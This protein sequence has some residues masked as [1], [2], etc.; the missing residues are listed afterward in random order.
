MKFWVYRLGL[1][2]GLILL[3]ISTYAE[4]SKD[5]VSSKGYRLFFNAQQRQQIKVYAKEGEFIQVGSSHVGI[6]GGFIR[7]IRPDGTDHTLFDNKGVNFQ[8]GII[9]NKT[10][11]FAGPTGGGTLNGPGYIPGVVPVLS[12]EE[13]IW[14]ITLEYPA[15]STSPFNNVLNVDNWQRIVDQPT[16]QRVVLAWDITVSKNAAAN[17]GGDMLTGRVFTQEIS[18]VVNDNGNLT[19]IDLYVLSDEG[20]QYNLKMEDMDPWGWFLSSNNRGIVDHERKPILRS[21]E[22]TEFI[23]SWQASSWLSGNNYLYEPQT[24]DFSPIANNKLFFN[25]PDP[26]LPLEASDFDLYRNIKFKNWLNPVIPNYNDPLFDVDFS[27]YVADT[28]IYSICGQYVMGVGQGGYI[29]FETVGRGEVELRID[30]NQN[31]SYNDPEDVSMNKEVLGGMDSIF[32]DGKDNFGVPIPP[33]KNFP[34]TLRMSGTIY[35]GEMHFLVF[36]VENTTGGVNLTRLNGVNPGTVSFLYDHSSFGGGVSGGGIPGD[37]QPTDQ[38]YSYSNNQGDEKMMDY[39][40]FISTSAISDEVTLMIDIVD[41][42]V[43]PSLDSDGDGIIDVIDLDDDNDG[44]PDIREFCSVVGSF[45]CL[46]GGLDP[47]HDEDKDKIL[48]FRDANDPAFT[49]P[50]ADVDGDGIC[51]QVDGIYDM[52]GD[53][54]PDHLD[55]DSDNDGVPDMYEAGHGLADMEGNGVINAPVA[56]FGNNGFYNN[57][58]SVAN[59]QLAVANYLPPDK[60]NDGVPDN[61]DRESDNDGINDVAEEDMQGL[62][63]NN[64]GA[65]DDG[66]GGIMVDSVGIPLQISPS[67][68]GNPLS[69]PKDFD[70]DGIPNYLD[71]DSDNDGL[72]DVI[73]TVNP[74]GD[75]NGFLGTG[76]DVDLKVNEFGQ[77]YEDGAGNPVS[78]TSYPVNTD[79]LGL[80]DFQDLDSDADGIWDT[81]E[82][83]V[84]DPDQDGVSGFGIP[85]VNDFGVPIKDENGDPLVNVHIPPDYDGDGIPDFQD[86]DSD[87]DGISDGYE[88]ETGVPCPD[89]DADGIPDFHDLDSDNDGLGDTV[90]CPNGDDPDCPD[91]DTDGVDDFRDPNSFFTNDTDGDGVRDFED[92]DN[93]NDGIPDNMEFCKGIQGFACLPGAKDPDGD[94]DGDFIPNYWDSKDLAVNNG[95]VDVN[96]DGICDRV[97]PAYDTD[98]D[99]VAN[100]VDLDSD[101]DGLTDLFEAG[102]DGPDMNGNGIIDGPKAIF[103][104]NGLYNP[105]A[106]DPDAFTATINYVRLNSDGDVNFDHLDLDSDN[107]GTYDAAEEGYAL[108]DSDD[109][110]RLDDGT[111]SPAV[112]LRGIALQIDPMNT[113]DPLVLPRDADL[114]G[115]PDYRD[116]DS[117]NDGIHDVLENKGSDADQDGEPGQ[118]P[119]NV[120]AHGRLL[121]DAIGFV[122]KST[123]FMV[124]TD[125]DAEPDYL[126]L[127]SDGDTLPDVVE[128]PHA[129]PD[130]DFRPGVSPVV[131]NTRGA[132]IMDATGTLLQS[133]SNPRDLDLDLAPDFQDIDRDG[134]GIGDGYECPDPWDCVDSDGDGMPDVDDLNSDND[135]WTD[136]DECP[137]GEPCPDTDMNFVDEFRQFNCWP[138]VTPVLEDLPPVI[139]VCQGSE[140]VLSG[141]NVQVFPA[142]LTYT[143]TGPG[144]YKVTNTVPNGAPLTA[145]VIANLAAEG[146]YTLTVLSSQGCAGDTVSLFL[147]VK[148]VPSTPI[149]DID[150]AEICIG[151]SIILSSQLY[152]GQDVVYTWLFQSPGGS[153]NAIG[154]SLEP[155][156][157]LQNAQ[158]DDDGGYAVN[159]TVEGCTSANALP[160]NLTVLPAAI[161]VAQNDNYTIPFTQKLLQGN[162][163]T[164]DLFNT[165]SVLVT[166]VSGPDHGILTMS[167]DGSF[168]YEPETG[169]TGTVTIV[170]SICGSICEEVCDEGILTIEIS[171][172]LTPTDCDIPNMITPNADGF[173]DLFIIPCLEDYPDHEISIFNRWGDRVFF[174]DDYQQDWDGTYQGNPLPNTTYFYLIQF[175]GANPQSIQGWVE[176]IRE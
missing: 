64:D 50:C 137:G 162:L 121:T 6:A 176:I 102:H 74:D 26:G 32:W 7:V 51:D 20:I 136:E 83:G 161:V 106:T 144:L 39:W 99:G 149:I 73:E 169:F 125:L 146:N 19:D 54:V 132:L 131:V 70:G 96:N 116:I 46:P 104:A 143:W 80:P 85:M 140:I 76:A 9:Y 128:A 155:I 22:D 69:S 100:H 171:E 91:S 130:K 72:M 3:G 138:D 66:F 126:D 166:L 135:F 133:I 168:K 77:V 147:D 108:L 71:H 111:G 123:S 82:A 31:G 154:S 163:L 89:T 34:L 36:D 152:T 157:I 160:F 41:S 49:N 57:I 101:N 174:S 170:Y 4:G 15:Y 75:N 153:F 47:S 97:A 60:D 23:R 158:E 120:D 167:A 93:D 16:N 165:K 159:V 88:C 164:N 37:P 90:E 109:D 122:I 56:E 139:E 38:P 95:C 25:V 134:D 62:D 145:P 1:V 58:S 113:G 11:E 10:Q 48:N 86:T 8:K 40:S 35:S 115:V 2:L 175:N 28:S 14:T 45:T 27:A 68:S 173:N 18:Y 129:D 151:D 87:N 156:Y 150:P 44:I 105:L 33:Q 67:A 63:S 24:K 55:L 21:A 117:D 124:N 98:G 172:D 119:V 43:D 79:M 107:D 142:D 112:G 94:E 65:I 13:G 52:D 114:D 110:G 81:Y 61:D 148:P 118:G 59:G 30:V 17:D 5:L 84:Y 103:G 141:Q 42:C 127:D 53:G 12:G 29:S 92:L 78:T